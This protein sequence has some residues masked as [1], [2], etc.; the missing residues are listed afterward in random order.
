MGTR[1][2]RCLHIDTFSPVPTGMKAPHDP[3]DGLLGKPV[4]RRMDIDG[5]PV[6]FPTN[7]LRT[8]GEI[9]G[10]E[11]LISPKCEIV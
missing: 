10:H 8:G 7:S 3:A 5:T 11:M 2:Y 6:S 4:I 1:S 9:H